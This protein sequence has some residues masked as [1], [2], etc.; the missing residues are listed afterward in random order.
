MG[1]ERVATLAVKERHEI[2][3]HYGEQLEQQT[4]QQARTYGSD[5]LSSGGASAEGQSQSP[6]GW[7]GRILIRKWTLRRRL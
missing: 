7:S 1:M 6:A 2:Q 4:R 5:E 3:Q